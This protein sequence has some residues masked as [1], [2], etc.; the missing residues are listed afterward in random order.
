[1]S[2]RTMAT[3]V[4]RWNLVEPEHFVLLDQFWMPILP[5]TASND[6]LRCSQR[7]YALAVVA[8]P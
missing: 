8:S 7:L 6:S 2:V 4:G 3:A 5:A 1:M